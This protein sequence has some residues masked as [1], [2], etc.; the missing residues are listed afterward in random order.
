MLGHPDV[1]DFGRKFKIAYSGCKDRACG[2]TSLH[3]LGFIAR[4]R[5]VDGQQQRGFECYVGG[6]LGAVPHQ[7]KLFDAFLPIEEMLPVAQAI[8]RVFA[9][10]GEKKNRARARIKFLVAKLGI[11]EF[12]R[13]VLEE[14]ATLAPDEGWTAL[15]ADLKAHVEQPL[16]EARPLEPTAELPPGFAAWQQTNVVPQA[17]RDYCVAYVTLPLGDATGDQLRALAD[18]ARRYCGDTIRVTVDQ[19]FALRWVSAADLPAL[20]RDLA[21]AGLGQP[22]ASSIL[23]LTACPGTDTCKL[24]I[25]SSRGLAGEL[26][27][28]LAARSEQLDTAVRKLHIKISGCF[29]SCGQHHAA[30]LGFYGVNRKVGGHAVPHF[31][32]VVGGQW[33]HNAGSYGLAIA[34]VPSKRIPEVVSLFID[35]YVEQR[36][37]DESFAAMVQRLGK[38]TVKS[39]LIDLTHVPSYAEDPSYYSDWA[40]PR[41]FSIGDLGVGECAGQ[42]VSMADFG[43]AESERVVFE[44]QLKL[45]ESAHGEA[46]ELAYRAMLRAARALVLDQGGSAGDDPPQIVAQFR[47]RLYDTRLFFDP[48]AGGKFGNYLFRAHDEGFTVIS[49]DEGRQRV[50]EAQLFIEAAH[51]CHARLGAS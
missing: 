41:E 28:R 29:N 13:L 4:T 33:E 21:A 6:G 15:L 27:R 9:R 7:A 3:D 34:A 48:Y 25:A 30:D 46:A 2:L 11:E 12:R 50:E 42:V 37:P 1:Q 19:N 18:I 8:C 49:P 43:L 16:K 22:G 39:W 45:D 26:R 31:Q 35:R 20:Y 17:Q 24:G 51:A 44:A 40:D 5:E 36:Q 14:R 38:A 47:E 23:D 32:V 10:L